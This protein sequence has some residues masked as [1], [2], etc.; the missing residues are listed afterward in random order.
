MNAKKKK[1]FVCSQCNKSFI[2]NAHLKDHEVKHTGMKPFVCELCNKRFARSGSLRVHARSHTGEIHEYICTFDDCNKRFTSRSGFVNH[3][4]KHTEDMKKNADQENAVTPTSSTETAPPMQITTAPEVETDPIVYT[5]PIP[6]CY[7]SFNN[8]SSLNFHTYRVHLGIDASVCSKS[9]CIRLRE[10]Y[11]KQQIQIQ[12]LKERIK[13]LESLTSLI[14]KKERQ[15]FQRE[16]HRQHDFDDTSSAPEDAP[17]IP[18]PYLEQEKPYVCGIASCGCRFSTYKLLVFHA[19]IHKDCSMSEILNNQLAIMEG[20]VHCPVLGCEFGPGH[21]SLSSYFVLKRHYRRVHMKL[22]LTPSL[23]PEV[24]V[25]GNASQSTLELLN[26]LVKQG[27]V[28]IQNATLMQNVT[29]NHSNISVASA[30]CSQT[31]TTHCMGN[32]TEEVERTVCAGGH[33]VSSTNQTRC[34]PHP[35]EW[36]SFEVPAAPEENTIRIIP[37]MEDAAL[38]PPF[39]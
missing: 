7:K 19:K 6:G 23:P 25:V 9:R 39:S 27:A 35:S 24:S 22:D 38:W 29:V 5:C 2:D 31:I 17:V 14:S 13:E 21:K 15:E 4:K 26:E 8:K 12:K 1:N 11:L 30:N 37:N 10:S 28:V 34:E 18:V 32:N 36:S 3:Q 33:D 20:R 16:Y